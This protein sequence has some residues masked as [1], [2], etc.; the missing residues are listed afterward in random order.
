MLIISNAF[1][2]SMLS[3]SEELMFEKC[4]L[5]EIKNLIED[6]DL[7]FHS[8][9][10]HEGTAT[11]FSQILGIELPANREFYKLQEKD[12]LVVGSLNARLP[13]GK[14]LSEEELKEVPIQWWIVNIL[15]VVNNGKFNSQ[16]LDNLLDEQIKVQEAIG[17]NIKRQIELLKEREVLLKKEIELMKSEVR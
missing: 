8:I 2:I 15:K 9:I 6:C 5:R 7:T 1:S 16:E 3:D 4:E 14:V 12:V 13:E 11:V 10:G 17:E